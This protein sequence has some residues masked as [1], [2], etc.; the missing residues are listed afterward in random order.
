MMYIDREKIKN[1][2]LDGECSNRDMNLYL[3]WGVRKY[4]VDVIDIIINHPSFIYEGNILLEKDLTIFVIK[5]DIPRFKYYYELIGISPNYQTG[6]FHLMKE[7][8]VS[9]NSD[10]L[11][12]VIDEP[13]LNFLEGDSFLLREMEKKG[14]YNNLSILLQHRDEVKNNK[15]IFNKYNFILRDHKL[16]HLKNKI[17]TK[18][19]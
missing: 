12:L 16:N 6:E 3:R 14:H 1:L 4:A 19:E 11:K 9:E 15:E 13:N 2:I 10:F 17:Y 18:K 7:I 5:N 8:C